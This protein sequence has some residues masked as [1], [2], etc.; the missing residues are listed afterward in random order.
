MF[1]LNT[2]DAII[3]VPPWQLSVYNV[4][5]RS[6]DDDEAHLAHTFLV[7]IFAVKKSKGTHRSLNSTNIDWFPA[8]QK[9]I[10]A[11]SVTDQFQA[12]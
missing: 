9:H 11:H 4:D 5:A 7:N 6:D 10:L 12:I 2:E 8:S 1:L 3:Q